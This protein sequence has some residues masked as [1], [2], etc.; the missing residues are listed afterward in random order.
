MEIPT[1]LNSNI[2]LSTAMELDHRKEEIERNTFSSMVKFLNNIATQ[3]I[4]T[5]KCPNGFEDIVFGVVHEDVNPICT[6]SFRKKEEYG[7][8]CDHMKFAFRVYLS[9]GIATFVCNRF[10]IE[11]SE[12]IYEYFVKFY[13]TY[14][15]FYEYVFTGFVK[16]FDEAGQDKNKYSFSFKDETERIVQ[17]LIDLQSKTIEEWERKRIK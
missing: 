6:I 5:G 4:E 12:K 10:N 9:T 7:C 13:K 17:S 8:R 11:T 15:S 1:V 2:S 16:K 14:E 3:H